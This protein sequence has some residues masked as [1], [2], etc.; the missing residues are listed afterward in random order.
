MTD[1]FKGVLGGG[2]TLIL[3]WIFPAG[4]SIGTFLLLIFP[5]VEDIQPLTSL[6]ATSPATRSLL[7]L[8]VA[9]TLGVLLS[10]IQTPLYRILEGYLMWPNWLGSVR[11]RRH[12]ARRREIVEAA[13]QRN[14]YFA[15]LAEERRRRYPD[16]EQDIVPTELGNAI[17]RFEV[18]GWNTYGLNTQTLWYRIIAVIPESASKAHDTARANVDFFVCLLYCHLLV[19]MTAALALLSGRQGEWRLLVAFAL[20]LLVAGLS[21]RLAIVATDEWASSIR[22]LTDLCRL[23][24]AN[25]LGLI[26]PHTLQEEREM[27]RA[28][29]WLDR[30]GFS[31]EASDYLSAFRKKFD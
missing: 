15:A 20:C 27:W 11:T 24:L 26:L 4:L 8:A 3:G 17:R 5:S 21:Y 25:A 23:P 18:Y 6:A 9:V 19:G 31:Q 12:I 29:Y 7:V 28:V 1:L 14:G 13:K 22:A 30:T 16:E 10:A 2:W